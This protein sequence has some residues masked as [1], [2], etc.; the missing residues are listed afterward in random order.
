MA[1]LGLGLELELGLWLG[2]GFNVRIS[3]VI[4]MVNVRAMGRLSG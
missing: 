2:P 3:R 1:G 4:L